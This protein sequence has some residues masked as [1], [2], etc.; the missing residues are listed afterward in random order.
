[1]HD[2]KNNMNGK[3]HP[4]ERLCALCNTGSCEDEIHSPLACLFAKRFKI[5]VIKF[6]FAKKR[7]FSTMP[8][9]D[10]LINAISS[11]RKGKP[12]VFSSQRLLQIISLLQS[13]S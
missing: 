6:Y 13:Q 12:A 11:T 8:K 7:D 3:R 4:S 1:M 2:N 5:Y 10:V 9:N